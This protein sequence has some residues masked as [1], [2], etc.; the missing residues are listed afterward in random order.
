MV[1]LV[2]NSFIALVFFYGF[3][4]AFLVISNLIKSFFQ[5]MNNVSVRER[6]VILGGFLITGMTSQ[7]LT[8]PYVWY[9]FI[10]FFAAFTQKSIKI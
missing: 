8:S 9:T 3:I 10:I 7:A 5:T 1:C 4:P 6:Y 2:L